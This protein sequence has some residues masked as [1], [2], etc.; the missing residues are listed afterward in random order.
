MLVLLYVLTS[1]TPIS[2]TPT[3]IR[4]GGKIVSCSVLGGGGEFWADGYYFATVS[5]RGNWKVVEQ[6]VKNQDKPQG[7]TMDRQ[8]RLW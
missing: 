5:V 1:S 3:S 7:N 2:V 4:C 6:Y 8:L